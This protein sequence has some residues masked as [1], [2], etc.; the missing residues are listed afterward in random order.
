M[1]NGIFSI[2]IVFAFVAGFQSYCQAQ[3][4]V[5]NQAGCTIYVSAIQEDMTTRPRCDWCGISLIRTI[6]AGTTAVFQ[7]DSS[8]GLEFWNSV[9]WGTNLQ[10]LTSQSMNPYYGGSCL[11]DVIFASCNGVVLNAT[12]TQTPGGGTVQIVIQ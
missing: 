6:P 11:P 10:G 3:M 8:C 2:L 5:I 4:T 9:G 1:K 7:P 12:W